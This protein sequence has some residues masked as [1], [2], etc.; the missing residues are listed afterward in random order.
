MFAA[1][2][3]PGERQSISPA[4]VVEQPLKILSQGDNTWKFTFDEPATDDWKA[5]TFDDRDW[6]ALVKVPTPKLEWSASGGYQCR[7][8]TELDAA[9]LGLPKPTTA[10]GTQARIWIRKVLD[11][12][13]PQFRDRQP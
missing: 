8:C 12:P 10:E 4:E 9:C 2:H 3:K 5:L 11:I 1:T 6:P 7:K 13:P